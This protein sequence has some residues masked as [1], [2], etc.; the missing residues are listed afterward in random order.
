MFHSLQHFFLFSGEGGGL[1]SGGEHST[2]ITRVRLITAQLTRTQLTSDLRAHLTWRLKRA[3]H[4]GSSSLPAHLAQ[5][6]QPSPAS[7]VSSL[8]CRAPCGWT[9]VL[10]PSPAVS[11]RCPGRDS[12]WLCSPPPLQAALP[13]SL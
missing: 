8:P 7:P 13:R 3:S 10:L 2:I 1:C 11:H 4:S 12:T 6:T 9:P 5:L